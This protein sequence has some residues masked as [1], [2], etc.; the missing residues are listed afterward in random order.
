MYTV[1]SADALA[2][3]GNAASISTANG[4]SF[5]SVIENGSFTGGNGGN[6]TLTN[7]SVIANGGFGL[8]SDLLDTDGD[9][10]FIQSVG[11][12]ITTNIGTLIINDGIF[13][14]GS[15]G[16]A[17]TDDATGTPLARGGYGAV[18]AGGTNIINGGSFTYGNAGLT[19]SSSIDDL[20]SAIKVDIYSSNSILT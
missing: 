11:G 14:G 17:I 1:N 4:T 19:S 8:Y 13:T 2:N 7:G 6:I 20:S 3:G 15:G 9:S 12:V 5:N 18:L 10:L 16:R